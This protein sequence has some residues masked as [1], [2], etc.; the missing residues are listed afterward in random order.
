MA[1][2]INVFFTLRKKKT[3][4]VKDR[5]RKL[6]NKLLSIKGKQYKTRETITTN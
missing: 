5:Y 4:G 3:T 6:K 1:Q 2:Y